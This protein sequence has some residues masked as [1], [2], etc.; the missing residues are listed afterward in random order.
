MDGLAELESNL[1]KVTGNDRCDMLC[2]LAWDYRNKDILKTRSLSEQALK[3]S[4]ELGY[5]KG[6]AYSLRNLAFV[7]QQYS[8]YDESCKLAY[9]AL[10]LFEKCGDLTGEASALNTL[11]INYY[12]LGD[13]ENAVLIHLK[14]LQKRESENDRPGIAASYINLGNVYSGLK[15]YENCLKYYYKG[16]DV[17]I[18]NNDRMGKAAII[19]NI[20]SVNIMKG[21]HASAVGILEESIAIK[22]EISDE[23]GLAVSYNNL[24][25]CYLNLGDADRAVMF[26]NHALHLYEKALNPSGEAL[27]YLG[28]GKAF[29]Q[30]KDFSEAEKNLGKA[31]KI[32]EELE[33]RDDQIEVYEALASMYF[34]KGDPLSAYQYQKRS[35]ELL[36]KV[37]EEE[38]RK[39]ISNMQL[40]HQVETLRHEAEIHRLRNVE[41]KKL[42]DEVEEKN[43]E[44]T[45]SINYAQLIQRSM[46]P[47]TK[48]ILRSFEDAFVFFQP[49]NIVSGD[50]YWFH[51][52][53]QHN[54]S[55][56]CI[57]VLADCTGHG[58]P[59]AFMSMIGNTVLNQLVIERMIT[60][61]A[62]LLNQLDEKV[63]TM[64]KQYRQDS[65]SRDGMDIA[66]CYYD[67]ASLTLHYAGGNRPMLIY[68]NGKIN[69]FE[70]DKI[71]I[72][73][74][75]TNDKKFTAC[76]VN[77]KK[78]DAIYL[79]SDGLVDQ[80]GG[81]DDSA[82]H[83]GGKK[84]L[85]K[86][87][88]KFIEE[89]SSVP[90]S[91]QSEKISVI[92]NGWKGNLEQTD[93]VCLIGLK[94]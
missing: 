37:S 56:P 42:N 11:G 87:F 2:M 33:L 48:E 55:S 6:I 49:R 30:K 22:K 44:I 71:S 19:N 26:Q 69:E 72:G 17:M 12:R 9:Q 31:L 70:P 14:A 79:Y 38:T 32:F 62:V 8:R 29:H 78:G 46:L 13:F 35:Y 57:I 43:K 36:K 59:G 89:H 50:F 53:E 15:D 21:D 1:N 91:E 76:S 73:G 88:Y 58:V 90:M 67:P 25:E 40:L 27:C 93:D 24:G 82:R 47:D 45:D 84:F 86:R 16:L 28:L 54:E 74:F 68:S 60:D 94:I 5:Q 10:T 75:K 51:R 83:A 80:F 7:H 92:F 18:S 4:E 20:A 77:L 61:P 39:K 64:L 66:L 23:R 34:D 85:A 65:A 41:L 81:M 52:I 3:L 63:R